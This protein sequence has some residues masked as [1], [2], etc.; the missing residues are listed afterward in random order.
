MYKNSIGCLSDRLLVFLL[1]AVLI[2]FL[3]VVGLIDLSY[4][5]E[6]IR[7]KFSLALLMQNIRITA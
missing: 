1:A 2:A 5:Q 6:N 4:R 3:L 7:S